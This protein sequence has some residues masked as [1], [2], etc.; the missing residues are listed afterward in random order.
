MGLANLIAQSLSGATFM[1][2]LTT[3]VVAA[4]YLSLL[5]SMMADAQQLA[6]DL[7]IVAPR[8][9]RTLQDHANRDLKCIA[10]TD[11]CRICERSGKSVTCP[12]NIGIACQ[13]GR[14]RC[15]SRSNTRQKTQ[16]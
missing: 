6:A 1:K 10:W 14:I 4:L 15:T 12:G 11:G 8:P 7:P 9:G 3:I 16:M 5:A 13:P 2:L